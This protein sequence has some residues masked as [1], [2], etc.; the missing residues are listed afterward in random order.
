MST[1]PETEKNPPFTNEEVAFLIKAIWSSLQAPKWTFKNRKDLEKI[2][3]AIFTGNALKDLDDQ[4]YDRIF[5]HLVKVAT[6]LGHVLRD[7]APPDH[8]PET[9]LESK[10]HESKTHE[11]KTLESKTLESNTTSDVAPRE[12]PPTTEKPQES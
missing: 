5:P 1:T 9:T 12:V 3:E 11:S 8:F 4:L 7:E 10:T 6:H 2:G